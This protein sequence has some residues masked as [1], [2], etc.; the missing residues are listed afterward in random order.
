MESLKHTRA[1]DLAQAPQELDGE[2]L[3]DPSALVGTWVSTNRETRGIIKLIV[4]SRNGLFTVQVFGSFP[5]APYD[6]GEA[7]GAAFADS[8]Q[9]NTGV[10]FKAFYDFGFME[11]ALAAYLNKR[12]LVLDSYNVFKDGS[13]R[14][15]YFFRDHF[16][17]E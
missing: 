13:P 16:Y 15:N 5:D 6:W 3:I 2:V 10:G 9:S 11:T 4:S 7:E 1:N 8:V 12:I 17:Q 14:F